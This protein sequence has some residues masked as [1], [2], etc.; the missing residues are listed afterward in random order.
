MKM[1]QNPPYGEGSWAA[2]L[3]RF[4]D[5][6]GFDA[7]ALRP[8]FPHRDHRLHA[9]RLLRREIVQLGTIRVHVIELPAA[10]MLRDQLPLAVAQ[11]TVAL[12]L[13]EDR[14]RSTERLP[15]EGGAQTRAFHRGN[16]LSRI[17]GS[18]EIDRGRH[19]VDQVARLAFKFAPAGDA[20]RPVRDERGRDA[21]LV[22][23]VLV[24]A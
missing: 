23:P 24:L 4:L 19:Q 22:L 2:G 3:L 5:R 9:L 10:G 1:W 16:I 17:S 6:P 12:V 18:F 20:G 7:D 15:F 21:A 11:R 14:G 8:A 13:P